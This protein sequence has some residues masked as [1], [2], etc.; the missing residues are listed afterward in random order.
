VGELDHE[1]DDGLLVRSAGREFIDRIEHV[2]ASSGFSWY[3][4]PMDVGVVEQV[5]Q[6]AAVR[7][8]DAAARDDLEA[9]LRTVGRLQSWLAG[10]KAALTSKLAAQVS[11]P[12]KTIADCTRGSTRDAIRDKE[13]ADTLAATPGLA[14]A[15]DRAD[16]TAGHVDEVTRATKHLDGDERA[17]LLDR[18]E[19]GGLLDVAA[20]AS[21]ED[22]RRRLALEVKNIQ[23]DDGMARLERQRR[24]TRLRTWTDDEGMWCISGRFDPVTGVKLAARLDAAINTLF[25]EATPATCPADP[26][27]KQHHLRALALASLVDGNTIGARPGR[28]EYVVV[29]D[30]TQ[31]DGA[32]GPVVDWGLPVEIPRRIL[33]EMAGEADVR[34]VVVRNGV[35]LHAPG[36]LDLGRTTRLANRAQRRALRALYATC[37]IPG[38]SVHYVRCKLH[39]VTWW[40]HG[41]R[42]DLDNLLPVCAHHHTKIHD[43]GW[44]ITLG[45]N[46]E[47]TI[48]F[49]DGTIRC[50]GPPTRAAA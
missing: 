28:P 30:T 50:T 31:P 3:D 21:V 42:T 26:I 32:G 36:E 40:R 19:H 25:A 11:F 44:D 5:Q 45:P 16:V 4:P 29:V 14:D 27:E 15:L 38:C 23:R 33:A 6:V 35:V 41:G 22:W 48:R 18:V 8:D 37:A 13:R 7:A 43:A 47:L 49:P 39:H 17:E 2:F 9:A 34:A 1:L 24:A 46:R 20:V 12:E 10:T